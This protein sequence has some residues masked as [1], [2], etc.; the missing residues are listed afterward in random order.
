MPLDPGLVRNDLFAVDGLVPCP[1]RVRAVHHLEPAVAK[2]ALPHRRPY[3]L[4]ATV[5]PRKPLVGG[6]FAVAAVSNVNV[7]R[8]SVWTD[9][10]GRVVEGLVVPLICR[11]IEG[12][13]ASVRGKDANSSTGIATNQWLCREASL[14]SSAA[15]AQQEANARLHFRASTRAAAAAKCGLRVRVCARRQWG[16]GWG[17]GVGGEGLQACTCPAKAMS[18][19]YFAKSGSMAFRIATAWDSSWCFVFE[20]SASK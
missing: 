16:G 7:N 2:D 5:E 14:L 6:P 10:N 15:P 20:L 8:A 11:W 9:R 12:R 19:P 3:R 1:L 13:Q 4:G 18:T 17:V